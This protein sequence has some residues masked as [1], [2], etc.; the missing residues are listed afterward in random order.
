M[1]TPA[2]FAKL[3]ERAAV[4]SK[5]EI[6]IPTEIVMASVAT[7][8]KAAIGTYEYGWPQLAD[9]TKQNRVSAGFSENEPLIRRGDMRASVA[10]KAELSPEGAEG[11]VY[12]DDK[13]ALYQELGTN[14][15]IPPRS[16]LFKSLWLCGPVLAKTFGAFA[17]N[18]FR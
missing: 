6:N 18:L 16:F 3:L 13:I 12:S 2:E 17:E 10:W 5:T 15:G 14:R 9:S 1:M 8:A 7:D 11:L 4:R